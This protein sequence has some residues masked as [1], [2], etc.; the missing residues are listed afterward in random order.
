MLRYGGRFLIDFRLLLCYK[1]LERSSREA[2]DILARSGLADLCRL[3]PD[4][5]VPFAQSC[6]YTSEVLPPTSSLLL[7][8]EVFSSVLKREQ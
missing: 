4:V 1:R 7:L 8:V 5:A 6:I 3:R 2:R